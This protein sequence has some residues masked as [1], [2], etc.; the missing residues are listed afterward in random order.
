[1]IE[2]A[3]EMPGII[4]SLVMLGL[5]GRNNVLSILF[6]GCGISIII[7]KF[8]NKWP[9]V[10]FILISKMMISGCF[11][12]IYLYTCELLPTVLR[13][14]GFC[15]VSSIGRLAAIIVPFIGR[16]VSING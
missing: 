16:I 8:V 12:T 5:L 14:T 1:M 3:A 4:L 13:C 11:T 9:K 2:G 10:I 7:S 15:F 6:I